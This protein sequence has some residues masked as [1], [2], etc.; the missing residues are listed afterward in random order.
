[1]FLL[2]RMIVIKKKE[3]VLEIKE[4][5]LNIVDLKTG[6]I[7]ADHQLTQASGKLIQRSC[8]R[9]NSGI[10]LTRLTAEAIKLFPNAKPAHKFIKLLAAKYP[11]Y[12][13]DQLN[14]ILKLGGDY[15]DKEMNQALH[16]CLKNQLISAN[17]LKAA[18]KK[19]PQY[20]KHLAAVKTETKSLPLAKE[21]KVKLKPYQPEV[22]SLEVY[23][24]ILKGDGDGTD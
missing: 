9:R 13:R 8:D 1:M 12:L 6:E 7:L 21:T 19:L 20:Q 11:R 15:S 3:V 10:E 22:R 5:K 23:T 14:I 16:Y 18:I 24:N 4:D 17:D 2:E